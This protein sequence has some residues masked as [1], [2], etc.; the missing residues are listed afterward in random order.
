MG[1][2]L[3]RN[4]GQV[5]TSMAFISKIDRVNRHCCCY[6]EPLTN[7]VRLGIIWYPRVQMMVVVCTFKNCPHLLPFYSYLR[8][9]VW[10]HIIYRPYDARSR[11]QNQKSL[12]PSLI[13][14]LFLSF[15]ICKH[16]RLHACMLSTLI[17]HSQHAKDIYIYE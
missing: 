7:I 6:C 4:G 9:S 10:W 13:S 5:A 14:E 15:L 3:N 17:P 1:I 8:L 12:F 11:Y 2:F 16:H